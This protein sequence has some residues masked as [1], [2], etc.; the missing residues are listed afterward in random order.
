[1]YR[2]DDLLL[3][4]LIGLVVVGLLGVA[5]FKITG[6]GFAM[7]GVPGVMLLSFFCLFTAT[8]QI[9]TGL[10]WIP[11]AIWLNYEG[12]QGWAFFTVVWGLFVNIIDNF[13]KPYL[14]S[15]GSGLPFALILMGVIGGLL[16]WG[17]IGIFLGPTMLATAYT[18]LTNW[19]G[20]PEPSPHRRGNG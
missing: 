17:F 13:I 9:G 15:H 5:C 4:R 11:V 2:S 8:L 18:L 6:L 16:A 1:M 14:I 3:E 10:V 19:L 12:Q 7:A 20:E